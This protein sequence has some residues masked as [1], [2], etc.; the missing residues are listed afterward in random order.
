MRKIYLFYLLLGIFSLA[1]CNDDGSE[2]GAAVTPGD[3]CFTDTLFTEMETAGVIQVGITLSKPAPR[4]YTI[5]VASSYENDVVEGVDYILASTKVEVEQGATEAFAEIEL[6]DNKEADPGRYLELRIMDAGGGNVVEPSRCRINILDDESQCAVAFVE[7][8][9]R[10]YENEGEVV[11][12]IRLEGTPSGK[13]VRFWV[14]RT[15][16]SAVEDEDFT[17]KTSAWEFELTAEND[18]TAIVLEVMD[19]DVFTGDRSIVY[20]IVEVQGA[21][22]LT[23]S[24]DCRVD[25]LDNDIAAT[26]TTANLT[27]EESGEFIYVPVQLTNSF[28]TNVTLNIAVADNSTAVEGTD[29]TM[30]KTVV[31]PAGRTTAQLQ[32]NVLD[33]DGVTDD[34]LLVLEITGDTE[35]SVIVGEQN[36][37][38]VS[39]LECDATLSFATTSFD[40]VSSDAG[41]STTVSLSQ[42]LQHDVTFSLSSSDTYVFSGEQATYT[43][44]TGETSVEVTWTLT[45]PSLEYENVW[46]L[47]VADVYGASG[48][49]TAEA[50]MVFRLNK[51]FWSIAFYT[52]QEESGEG[53]GNGLASCLID[54]DTGTWWHNQWQGLSSIVLPCEL[55]VN[56]NGP[57]ILTQLDLSRRVTS[58]YRDTRRANLYFTTDNDWE[59]ANWE[60]VGELTWS[61]SDGNDVT[62]TLT[63]EEG[64]Y[65]SVTYIRIEVLEGRE[66]NAA[67]LTEMTLYGWAQ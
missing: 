59:T 43:I 52:S 6:I 39:I 54:D 36:T 24:S 34:R 31:V 46:T 4:D 49:P 55:V 37:C 45:P 53:A 15:G 60:L 32:V 63:W 12:P 21:E 1:A 35:G 33:K 64:N 23:G 66:N 30:E 51:S 57:K 19:D 65:P 11:L 40:L 14:E 16:G 62:K 44:P 27:V 58:T 18:S 13:T 38:S 29:F 8:G 2:G 28:N 22:L 9:I 50:T 42:A 17:V 3:A 5:E 56:L 7:K 48:N 67:S 26:F 25:I 20:E 10:V 47:T 61:A 41:A